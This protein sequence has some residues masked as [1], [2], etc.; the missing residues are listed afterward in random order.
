MA[1]KNKTS[2]MIWVRT[3]SLL[4]VR[5]SK[6]SA[7]MAKEEEIAARMISSSQR[8]TEKFQGS[9]VCSSKLS[10]CPVVALETVSRC[11]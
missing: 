2:T 3:L 11:Y 7:N 5:K 8:A 4:S 10:R 6:Q 9:T 1:P